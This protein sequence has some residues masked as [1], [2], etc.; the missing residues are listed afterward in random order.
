MVVGLSLYLILCGIVS[1]AITRDFG[2]ESSH[3]APYLETCRTNSAAS[4]KRGRGTMVTDG[5]LEVLALVSQRLGTSLH[6]V[7][8]F[9]RAFTD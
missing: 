6:V 8:L 9:S 1:N 7:G 5:R 4:L 3:T 2:L